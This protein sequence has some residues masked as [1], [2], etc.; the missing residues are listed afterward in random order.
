[1]G[2]KILITGGSGLVGTALSSLL[3]KKGY[4]VAHLSRSADGSESVNTYVWDVLSEKMDEEAIKGVHAIIHLAGAGIADE[5][6]TDQ[7]KEVIINSRVKSAKL[8][9]DTCT[10]LGQWP[11]VFLS[12]SG[13]NFYGSVTSE[14]IY[15]EKDLPAAS[16]IGQ[17]CVLWEDAAQKFNIKSRVAMLRTGVVMSVE[18]G[19]LPKIDASIKMG[20]GAALGSGTQWMPYI[21]I[22]D[23]CYMYLHALES[24]AVQGPYNATNGDHITNRN[25]TKA[26]AKTLKK[27]LWL[28]AV[29]GFA[30]KLALGEMS[31]IL[32]EGSRASADKIASTG[33]KF[34]FQDLHSSL[35]DLYQKN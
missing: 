18:G 29:P 8:L 28:P 25:L 6:W 21:H 2:K 23:L 14:H 10:R 30:L 34:R 3:Q 20:V 15:T 9:Y 31:E 27:P 24:P 11:E 33:F 12:A 5:R 16:F 13:I 22:D 19:A 17:C 26:I 4:E 35:T 32:L 1:M 7:R